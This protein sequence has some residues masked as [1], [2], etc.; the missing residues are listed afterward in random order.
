MITSPRRYPAAAALAVGALALTACGGGS[1]GSSADDGGEGG[2]TV[3]VALPNHPWTTAIEER[4]PD[5]EAESGMTVNLTTFGE[6][7]LSDQYNVK[8]NTQTTDFDVMMM[9]P[10]QEGQL[11]IENGWLAPLDEQVDGAE[12]WDWSDFQEGPVASVTGEDDSVYAVPLVS[13]REV[14]Y[15][16]KALLEA[17]GVAVPQ[18]LEEL[19]QAA[20]ALH[21]PAGGVYGFVARGQRAAAVTQFSSFLF[22][23][24]GDFADGTEATLDTPEAEEAYDYYS[25]MLREYGPPGSTEMS[26]P[27]ALPIFAQGQAAFYTDGDSLSSNF[28]DPA[29]SR[30]TET[31][32]FAQFP[33]GPAGSKPYNIA[34]W[35]LGINAFSENTENAWEFIEWATGPETSADIQGSGVPLARQ[36]LWESP[37]GLDGFPAELAEVMRAST[38]IGVDHDRPQVINVG[39]ARDIVGLPIVEG[40]NGGDVTATLEQAQQDFQSF[41]DDENR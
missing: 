7:Q 20:A 30:V 23:F 25:R 34:S 31:I 21:D 6:D 22:S 38:E 41:L 19:E 4:I 11:F 37:E 36:S 2:G 17:K 10:L 13:E 15:Y 9:R 35:A 29:T 27:Q 18:T 28:A 3:N 16:N 1:G 12:E 33:E 39:E 40:I 24:G 32:G 26:W 14:L 5:Y 8:L